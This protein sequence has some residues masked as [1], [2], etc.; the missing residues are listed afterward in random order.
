MYGYAVLGCVGYGMVGLDWAGYGLA[1]SYLPLPVTCE[2][3]EGT[4]QGTHSCF[5][6]FSLQTKREE[7]MGHPGTRLYHP[8]K[9]TVDLNIEWDKVD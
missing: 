6:L 5:G 3:L 7:E 9:G 8:P 4:G 2:A 1:A